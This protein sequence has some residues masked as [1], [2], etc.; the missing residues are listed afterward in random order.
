MTSNRT[1]MTDVCTLISCNEVGKSNAYPVMKEET[2]EVFCSFVDG[3]VRNEYYDALKAG[4]QISAT[5]EVWE[6]DYAKQTRIE[7]GKTRYEVKRTYPSGY[8]T[9]YLMCSEAVR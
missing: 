9:L 4:M 7:H 2:T 8:G 3:A 6:D 1:P 5:I